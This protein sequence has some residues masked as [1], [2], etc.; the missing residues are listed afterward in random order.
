MFVTS[1]AAGSPGQVVFNGLGVSAGGA[2]T[3][4]SGKIPSRGPTV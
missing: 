4:T 3:L 1:H 2:G